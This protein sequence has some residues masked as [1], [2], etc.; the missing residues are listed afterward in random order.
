MRKSQDT[1]IEALMEHL[2]ETGADDMAAVFA[3]LFDLA[4]RIERERYLDARHYER[5]PLRRG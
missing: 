3:N 4:M 2:I 5:T 1:A